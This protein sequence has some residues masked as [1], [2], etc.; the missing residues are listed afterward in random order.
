MMEL[1]W[2][3][4]ATQDRDD[5]YEH[6]ELEGLPAR[7]GGAKGLHDL[8]R[9]ADGDA[10]LANAERHSGSLSQLLPCNRIW[11]QRRLAVQTYERM[12][13]GYSG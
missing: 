11:I 7:L 6:I 4:E 9:Q 2:T 1:F 10:L 8:R 5:I 13:L 12:P 3:P